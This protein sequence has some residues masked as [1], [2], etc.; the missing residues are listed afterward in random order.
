[1]AKGTVIAA[2]QREQFAYEVPYGNDGFH[3]GAFS[4]AM[5]R[6]LWQLGRTEPFA[7]AL[8]GISLKVR[9][10]A[11]GK[12]D[13]QDPLIE[14][15]P[16]SQNQQKPFFFLEVG[17]PAAEAVV[18]EGATGGSIPFW[19][20]GVSAQ[21]LESYSSQT[22]FV[23]IAPSG[24]VIGRL[25]Q[26]SRQGL[27]G[28]GKVIEGKAVEFRPGTL[29]REE[30]LG[31][32]TDLTLKV[33]VDASLGAESAAVQSALQTVRRV[34]VVPLNQSRAVDYIVGRLTAEG[35][36][37]LKQAKVE[38]LPVVGSIGLFSAGL[39]PVMDSFSPEQQTGVQ[40]VG[41]LRQKLQ[42]LLAARILQL[43]VGGSSSD[44]KVQAVIKDKTRGGGGSIATRGAREAGLVKLLG[45]PKPMKPD[46]T[47]EIEIMNHETKD[48]YIAALVIDSDSNLSIL[49]P[50]DWEAPEEASRVGKGQSLTIPRSGEKQFVAYGPAG[51]FELL[52]LA[53]TEPLRNSLRGIQQIARSRNVSRG[54]PLGLQAD[55]PVSVMEALLG[56]LHD[57][58]RAGLRVQSTE[59][60]QVDGSQ[61]ALF[62]TVMEV[63]D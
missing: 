38:P 3:A 23:A 43:T 30:I 2:A 4:Y 28:L 29:L 42:G 39:A 50:V 37:R 20:G 22:I 55:E 57:Q 21:A 24:K 10:Q 60:T 44:L 8:N 7:A 56:D 62:S 46:T 5:S 34:A 32:P 33:A 26:T 49:Y 12:G 15:A 13:N 63:T 52:L 36:N 27:R 31:V 19:L 25:E 18:L 58:T 53:S 45:P 47:V 51:M 6:Y 14:Y 17:T 48:L 35:L 54:T 16:Q 59:R 61:I 9:S 41:R 40:A 1:V 11:E